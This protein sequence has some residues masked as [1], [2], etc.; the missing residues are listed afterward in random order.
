MDPAT[1][2]QALASKDVQDTLEKSMASEAQKH[3]I[4]QLNFNYKYI[5][6]NGTTFAKATVPLTF[7]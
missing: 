2:E 6:S 4:K 1:I 5:E 7:D 3:H